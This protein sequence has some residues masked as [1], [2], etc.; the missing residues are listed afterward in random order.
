M[1]I[2]II[3]LCFSLHNIFLISADCLLLA[4]LK[5][6]LPLYIRVLY[7]MAHNFIYTYKVH[8]V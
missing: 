1:I 8:R 3:F 5:P 4:T 2:L 7:I 6:S